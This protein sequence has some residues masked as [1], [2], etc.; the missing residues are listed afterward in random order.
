MKLP[1]PAVIAFVAAFASA[2]Q[3]Q[4]PN[5]ST[6][7]VAWGSV[8]N[9]LRLGAALGSDPSKPT[10]RVIFQNVSGQDEDVLLGFQNGRKPDYNLK[11][12]AKA[13]DGKLRE[14]VELA[15]YHPV[16]GL[17]QPVSL[18]LSSV[19]QYELTFPLKNVIYASRTDTLEGLLK[20]GYSVRVSFEVDKG[21]LSMAGTLPHH[22]V[23]KVE[24]AEISPAR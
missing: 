21:A 4:I 1:L 17:L 16:E 9:G 22:W 10:I 13:P 14:G 18:V 23:G 15:A 8:V 3:P 11:F 24:S 12:I 19:R 6:A 2:Q 5:S 7:S 20:Q